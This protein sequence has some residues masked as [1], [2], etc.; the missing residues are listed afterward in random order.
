MGNISISYRIWYFILYVK[1]MALLCPWCVLAV[2]GLL[3]YPIIASDPLLVR[4]IRCVIQS[5]IVPSTCNSTPLVS[6]I[7]W[8]WIAQVPYSCLLLLSVSFSH[9]SELQIRCSV[10][11][12]GCLPRR[13]A[14]GSLLLILQILFSL[15]DAYSQTRN[16]WMQQ[17]LQHKLDLMNT[18]QPKGHDELWTVQINRQNLY[19]WVARVCQLCL[20]HSIL[21]IH[22]IRD[23]KMLVPASHEIER[24]PVIK[25]WSHSVRHATVC[26]CNK[27]GLTTIQGEANW[28]QFMKCLWKSYLKLCLFT[29]FKS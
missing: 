6:M 2:S 25:F 22:M 28:Y 8:R 4:P 11:N 23:S 3:N 18:N 24:P 26:N 5:M 10:V 7:Q 15:I 27:V 17:E 13:E 19:I 1:S 14:K 16:H 21:H 29:C 9:V 12:S 20:D